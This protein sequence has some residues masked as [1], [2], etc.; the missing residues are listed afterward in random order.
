[1]KKPTSLSLS[2]SLS[3][4]IYK[5][6]E[7]ES[8]HDLRTFSAKRLRLSW[9]I[10][11]SF[12]RFEILIVPCLF[13]ISIIRYDCRA[14]Y[15]SWREILLNNFLSLVADRGCDQNISVDFGGNVFFSIQ[16]IKNVYAIKIDRTNATLFTYTTDGKSFFSAVLHVT[17]RRSL[18][19]KNFSKRA[20]AHDREFD[21]NFLQDVSG[22]RQMFSPL[23]LSS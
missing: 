23:S 8:G 5:F 11:K 3:S 6:V 12:K 1:M 21:F 9:K 7:R 14:E 18:Y 16:E 4:E 19:D 2:S 15:S 17:P 20:R 10:I 22:A 13:P